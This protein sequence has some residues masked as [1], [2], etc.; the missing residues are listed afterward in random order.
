MS[1]VVSLGSY[2]SRAKQA[3]THVAKQ[4]VLADL[5]RDVFGVQLEDLIP[6]IEKKVGSRILGVRGRI[7]LLY[8]D[9]VF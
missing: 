6:G 3:N 7:D 8:S 2:I 5:L 1:S 4:L 9:V